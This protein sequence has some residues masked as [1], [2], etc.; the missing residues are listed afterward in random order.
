MIFAPAALPR[1]V[2]AKLN[3]EVNKAVGDADLRQKLGAQGVEFTGGTPQQADAFV[4]GEY[5]RWGKVIRATG[6]TAN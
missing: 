4:R 5:E 2:L 1:E 6:M 3:A